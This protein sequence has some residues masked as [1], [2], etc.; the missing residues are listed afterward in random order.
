M[1]SPSTEVKKQA[2]LEYLQMKQFPD[3]AIPAI[4]GNIEVETGGT[5]DY[6]T[7]QKGGSARGVLQLDAMWKPY[8][9]FLGGGKDNMYSQIDFLHDTI[10]GDSQHVI[11]RKNAEALRKSFEQDDVPTITA[12]MTDR[13]FRPG[14]PHLEKRIQSANAY[15]TPEPQQEPN[16]NYN[17]LLGGFGYLKN[18][19]NFGKP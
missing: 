12:N 7:K 17:E 5:F 16:V 15:A 13:W 18:L 2:L 3:K 14:K 9:Q 10:Y 1:A 8:Q 11:G 6:K 19:F 4:M